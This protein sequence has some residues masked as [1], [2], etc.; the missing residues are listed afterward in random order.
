M[1]AKHAKQVVYRYNGVASSDEVEQDFEGELRIPGK[2][3]FMNR[4]GIPWKVM[5]VTTE[6]SMSA[7][8]PIPVLRIFL[9][10]IF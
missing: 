8:G 5:H 2:G 10:D 6:Q 1:S 4:K 7:N 3:E 9:S